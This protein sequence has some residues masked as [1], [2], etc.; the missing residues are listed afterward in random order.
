MYFLKERR[1]LNMITLPELVDIILDKEEAFINVVR[2][3]FVLKNRLNELDDI[4]WAS[5]SSDYKNKIKEIVR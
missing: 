3:K 4:G 1:F 5:L 2:S